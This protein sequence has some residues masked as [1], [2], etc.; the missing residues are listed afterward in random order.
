MSKSILRR[1]Y[2]NVNWRGDT[3]ISESFAMGFICS[4]SFE[5]DLPCAILRAA[6]FS[7][8]N[9]NR[10]LGFAFSDRDWS[11]GGWIAGSRIPRRGRR[12]L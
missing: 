1:A 12:G 6:I 8:W 3:L 9:A 7:Q 11:S 10:Y 4:A 2:R 5:Q